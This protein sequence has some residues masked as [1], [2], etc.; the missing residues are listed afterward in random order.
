LPGRE[1]AEAIGRD[2]GVTDWDAG[3][4]SGAFRFTRPFA[5]TAIRNSLA[6]W[7]RE[8][9]GIELSTGVDEVSLALVADAWSRTYRSPAVTFAPTGATHES[10]NGVKIVPDRVTSSW[11]AATRLPAIGRQ[12]ARALDEALHGIRARYGAPTT[13]FVT[14]QLEYPTQRRAD[15]ESAS[16]FKWSVPMTKA[17][18]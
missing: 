5:A 8:E 3:H 14:M 11:P 1:K 15:R 7:N 13:D 4:D 6:F 17:P 18:R 12:P 9:L 16:A 10:R 2:I